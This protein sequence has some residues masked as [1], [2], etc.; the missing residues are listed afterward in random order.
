MPKSERP[1]VAILGAGPIGAPV[2]EPQ[3]NDATGAGRVGGSSRVSYENEIPLMPALPDMSW[4]HAPP[5]RNKNR[6][7]LIRFMRAP[8]VRLK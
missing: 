7:R 3:T 1:R 6:N 4:A 8:V 5:G 2:P